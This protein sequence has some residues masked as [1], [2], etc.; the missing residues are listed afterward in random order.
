M[1][2]GTACDQLNPHHCLLGRLHEVGGLPCEING[3]SANFADGFGCSGEEVRMFFHEMVRTE[4]APVFFVGEK[5][6]NE[7]PRGLL[8]IAHNVAERGQNHRVHVLHVDRATAPQ[9][10]VFNQP[11]E[12]V[13][14]PVCSVCRNH[15][16]M[17]VHDE[18]WL[19]AVAS[20][21]PSDNA[22]AT[23]RRIDESGLEPEVFELGGDV[24][25]GLGLA[26]TF[27]ATKI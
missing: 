8:S 19:G 24:F 15:V 22:R 14:R 7:V 27:S 3:V 26:I 9:H 18:G 16:E 17:P 4:D 6:K 23:V 11:L 5:G 25:G 20:G 21:D 13:D 10:A 2:S 12:R 1:A